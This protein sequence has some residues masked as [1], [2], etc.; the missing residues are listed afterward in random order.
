MQHLK[1]EIERK[2]P[3]N[4]DTQVSPTAA[5]K[6]NATMFKGRKKSITSHVKIRNLN[7]QQDGAYHNL[8]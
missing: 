5:S 3:K 8:S 4:T 7:P 1:Q 6:S 2:R